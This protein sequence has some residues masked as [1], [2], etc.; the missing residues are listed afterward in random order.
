[1]K[2]IVALSMLV[3]LSYEG[4][5]ITFAN[6]IIPIY[7]QPI[8]N[9]IPIINTGVVPNVNGNGNFLGGGVGVGVGVAVPAPNIENVY[10]WNDGYHYEHRHRRHSHDDRYRRNHSRN[11]NHINDINWDN[12]Y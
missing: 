11:R 7:E 2:K 6:N 4:K 10:N 5:P 8:N 1:M 3:G 12:Y 9:G